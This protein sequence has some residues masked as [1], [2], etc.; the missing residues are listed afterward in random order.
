MEGMKEK[1][2]INRGK[3]KEIVYSTEQRTMGRNKI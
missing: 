2:V 3:I 1:E